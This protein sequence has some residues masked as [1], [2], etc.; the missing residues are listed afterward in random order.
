MNTQNDAIRKAVLVTGATS[1]IGLAAA[2]ALAGRG[3]HII[4]AGRT[5]ERCAAAQAAV[6]AV[7]AGGLVEYVAADLSV[8]SQVRTLADIV[9]ERLAGERGLD[10]LVNNAAFVSSWYMASEDGYEMQFAVNHLAPFLLTRELLPLL[11]RTGAGRVITV[12]SGSHFRTRMR[13]RDVMFRTGYQCLFVYKQSKLA[14]VLFTHELNRRLGSQSPVRAY[15][16]DPG[17]V[18]T[19]IGE[20]GTTGLVKWIWSRRRRKG[21]SPEKAAETIVHLATMSEYI[22]PEASYWKECRPEEPSPYSRRER[23]M[24]RLWE[25]SERLCGIESGDPSVRDFA[26]AFALTGEREPILIQGGGR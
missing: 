7:S 10:V 11:A 1:G 6:S 14:N 12:S 26:S 23:E 18:D 3:F 24:T 5:L 13:W 25:L 19:G 15:A 22:D 8:Q 21:V 2:K 17:L 9:R 20:K 16:V 4:G